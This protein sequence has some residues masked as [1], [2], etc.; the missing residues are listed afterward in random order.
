MTGRRVLVVGGSGFVG[1][2][3]VAR[4]AALGDRVVVPTRRRDRA[5]EVV[6][7]PTVDVVEADVHDGAAL[8]GLATGAD[9][10]VNLAGILNE[11]R[12]ETF[13][14]AHVALAG[15]VVDACRKAGVRRLVHMSALGAGPE[16]P[17]RYLK[18]K[19]AAEALVANSGLDWSIFRPSVIFGP[20]DRFLNLFIGLAKFAPVF[21]LAGASARFQPVHVG[22]VVRA[23]AHALGDPGCV[24]RR[25]DLCGPKVYTLRELVRWACGTA[26]VGRPIVALAGPLA[27]LQAFALEHLP[28][29]LMSRDNLASMRVDNVCACPFPPEFGFAPAALEALAPAWLRPEAR[30]DHHVAHR[31][32]HGP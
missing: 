19:G 17:S 20:D 21:P 7:L 1:R 27:T 4:L 32:R 24:G 8:A 15:V 6:L 16:G 12:R 26:G 14:R 31:R 3:L 25:Y 28:G 29:G 5:R 30:F 13:E 23:M 2:A 11:S 10:V 9:A 22:D 18:S